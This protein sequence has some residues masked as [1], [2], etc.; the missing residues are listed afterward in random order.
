MDNYK[1]INYEGNDYATFK[2]NYKDHHLPVIMDVDDY[3][4]IYKTDKNWR[5]N[6]NG[7]V[8]CSHTMNGNT[9]DVYLHELIMLLKNKDEGSR[10]LNKPIVHINRVGLDNRREN[11]MY[12][13]IEKNL[14]KNYKKKKRT[15]ELPFDSGIEPDDIPTYI[16]Y[17]KPDS[18]HGARFAVNIGDVSWKTS[19]SFDLSLRY[20][21]EEAKLFVREL[22]R[23]RS[24]LLD[25]YS[26]NG[27]YTKEGKELLHTYYDII[28]YAGYKHIERFVPENNTIDL[29]KPNYEA[30]DDDEKIKFYERRKSI[31]NDI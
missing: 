23:S 2:I 16:W 9:K 17:M 7:F 3:K 26:M 8:S 4:V 10:N 28:H 30:L 11:L 14:N 1:L 27:D 15:I 13:I 31:K 20:K 18:S 6:T 25:E 21:L 19:S 24:D 29:L 12:D 22:L 5:C